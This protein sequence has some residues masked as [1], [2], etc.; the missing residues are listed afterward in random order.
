MHSEAYK[1]VLYRHISAAACVIIRADQ[2]LGRLYVLLSDNRRIMLEWGQQR[3]HA[4]VHTADTFLT[5][6]NKVLLSK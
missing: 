3:V 1:D 4:V 6:R 2:L 5:M